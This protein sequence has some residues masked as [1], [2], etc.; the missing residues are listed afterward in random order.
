LQQLALSY[1]KRTVCDDVPFWKLA[2]A[3]LDS[4]D[5]RAHHIVEATKRGRVVDCLAIPGAGSTPGATIPSRGISLVGDHL[6]ALRLHQPP[7]IAR[8]ADQQTM[9]DLRSVHPDDDSILISA[10]SA[11]PAR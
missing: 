6:N 7:V 10:L 9:I 5:N 3:S 1:L 11:L 8:V 4:L 2:T